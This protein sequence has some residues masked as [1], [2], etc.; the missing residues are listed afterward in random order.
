MAKKINSPYSAALTGGGFLYDETL[1]LLPLL[2]SPDRKALIKDEA[3]NNRLR[4]LN[5]E[6]ARKRNIA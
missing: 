1:K 4:M 2:Q 6:T 5:S 3:L